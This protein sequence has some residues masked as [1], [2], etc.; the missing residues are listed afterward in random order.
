MVLPH[1][2]LLPS[3][4]YC[5]RKSIICASAAASST[6]DALTLSIRPLRPCVPLFQASIASSTASLWWITSTGPSMRG[7]ELRAGHDDGDLDD[8]VAVRVQ[9]GHLAVDPDQVLVVLAQ[10]GVGHAA[11]HLRSRHHGDSRRS[12]HLRCHAR[13]FASS[14]SPSPPSLL[15]SLAVKFWLATRQMRHV[16]AHRDAV[17]AAFAGTVTL[18]GAPEGRRLHARQ[19]P[20]RPARARP[21]ARAVLLGWTLLGGL[22]ALNAGCCATRAAALGR[23]GLAAGAAGRL[24]AD[25]R[26][27]STC[28]SRCTAPSASRSAS[29]STR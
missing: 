25:R 13:R 18:A 12:L 27:C 2:G 24:R 19:G 4:T 29:A 8:A 3:G 23:H 22:D 6:V 9:A 21:S 14:P 16:A 10:R 1:I 17:P 28:R 7:V 15:L 26:R 11:G 20:L 5:A